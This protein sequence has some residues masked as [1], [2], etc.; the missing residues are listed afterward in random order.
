[1]LSGQRVTYREPP[2]EHRCRPVVKPKRTRSGVAVLA[3]PV[4][5]S[6][7][8]LIG[9][10]KQLTPSSSADRSMTCAEWL[11]VSDEERIDTADRLVGAS[12]ATL[13]RVVRQHQ[14]EGTP[15]A[16]LIRDVVTSLTK[17]CEVW[18]PRER[19]IGE[20]FSALY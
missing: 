3:L 13:E 19:T 9:S 20:V 2:A 18:P 8:Q 4:L 7:C 16:T 15:R 14:S 6:A 12:D 10:P 17:N 5:L 11:E 1:M